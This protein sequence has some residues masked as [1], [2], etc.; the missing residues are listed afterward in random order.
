V[1]SLGTE[2]GFVGDVGGVGTGFWGRA[3][4]VRG[5]QVGTPGT[6]PGAVPGVEHGAIGM[7]DQQARCHGFEP[8]DFYFVYF[9]S[10]AVPDAVN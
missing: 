2:P 9:L 7:P 3:P 8:G 4:A 6:L 5:N 10:F 1:R